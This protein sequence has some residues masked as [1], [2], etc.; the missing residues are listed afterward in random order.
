[1]FAASAIRLE[2]CP[3]GQASPL[4]VV[5]DPAPAVVE[6]RHVQT[7]HTAHVDLEASAGARKQ[8][9]RLCDMN[10]STADEWHI[11]ITYILGQTHISVPD[12]IMIFK[13][14]HSSMVG[15]NL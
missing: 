12:T 9:E 2:S 14:K 10:T 4:A 15:K 7:L 1:M 5:L 3:V 6:V 11:R 13:V 8:H